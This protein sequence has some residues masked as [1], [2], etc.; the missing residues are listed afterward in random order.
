MHAPRGPRELRLS[1]C[2][3]LWRQGLWAHSG[4][5]KNVWTLT[6]SLTIREIKMSVV[7]GVLMIF[8]QI[9]PLWP[10]YPMPLSILRGNDMFIHTLFYGWDL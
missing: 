1:F 8:G 2:A 7:M 10:P 6:T 4:R 3:S 9:P 5:E